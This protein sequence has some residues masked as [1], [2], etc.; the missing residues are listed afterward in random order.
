MK[1]LRGVELWAAPHLGLFLVFSPLS[2]MYSRDILKQ[3][4]QVP[5]G[6]RA[7]YHRLAFLDALRLAVSGQQCLLLQT[8]GG[9]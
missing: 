9:P 1:Y 6:L 4:L 2:A 3:P 5:R 7:V 8:L